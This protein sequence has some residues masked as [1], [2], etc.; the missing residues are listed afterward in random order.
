MD[1]VFWNAQPKQLEIMQLSMHLLTWRN[2]N[3]ENA[4]GSMMENHQTGLQ[5]AQSLKC[6]RDYGNYKR[7]TTEGA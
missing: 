5:D 2:S 6:S 1:Y 7:Y 3:W 4:T